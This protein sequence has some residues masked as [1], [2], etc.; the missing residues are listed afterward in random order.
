V[1][2]HPL[3]C[4]G[5]PLLKSRLLPFEVLQAGSKAGDFKFLGNVE[6]EEPG[7]LPVS[8]RELTA[9]VLNLGPNLDVPG[10]ETDPVGIKALRKHLRAL[11]DPHDGL[12]NKLLDL[13]D[14]EG[15]GP[16]PF[17]ALEAVSPRTAVLRAAVR[18]VRHEGAATK[19][20]LEQTP[21]QVDPR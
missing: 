19:P 7:L 14:A 10:P 6:V 17:I 3:P 2:G 16:A 11:E 4:P 1:A 21:E 9:E 5:D 20:A 8:L 15:F 18:D 13:L 12:P